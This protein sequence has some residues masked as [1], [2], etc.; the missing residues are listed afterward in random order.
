MVRVLSGFSCK[1]IGEKRGI[2]KREDAKSCVCKG[3]G[4]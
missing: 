4:Q 3:L 1:G 2:G